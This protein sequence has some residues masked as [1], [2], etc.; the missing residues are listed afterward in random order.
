M[1]RWI[2]GAALCV[3]GGC[4]MSNPDWDGAAEDGASTGAVATTSAAGDQSP[5][6]PGGPTAA[7]AGAT[8][9]MDDPN[10]MTGSSGPIADSGGPEPVTVTLQPA[11]AVCMSNMTL[12]VE[13]CTVNMATAG[14]LRVLDSD[15]ERIAIFMRFE[16]PAELDG[17]DVTR[18]DVK[19]V[20]AEAGTSLG[21]LYQIE[22]FTL[23]S[24]EAGFPEA[25]GRPLA[26]PE[27]PV[28]AG[29]DVWFGFPNEVAESSGQLYFGL[30]PGDLSEMFYG[31][32]ESKTPPLLVVTYLP[33]A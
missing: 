5:T 6:A 8:S 14:E 31:G 21:T 33:P 17:A 12:D 10:R 22:P 9:G 23:D 2:G 16:P 25:G 32:N 29:D 4:L 20:A 27:G 18:A 13:D 11:V 28:E 1:G 26:A 7:S 24:L 15:L 30:Y 3:F 19:L